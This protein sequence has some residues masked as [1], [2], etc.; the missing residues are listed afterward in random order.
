MSKRIRPEALGPFVGLALLTLV[1]SSGRAADAPAPATRRPNILWISAED[2]SAGTL[3]CY[4]GAARTPRIDS[5][6]AKGLRF[7]QAFSV[8]PVCAPSRSAIIT[9]VMPTTL[10][11][12]PMRCRATPPRHLVGFPRLLRDAG[13]F[14]TNAAKTDYNL[15]ASFD[16]GWHESNAKAHWRHRP[17]PRQPFFAVFNLDV[18]HESG[19]FEDKLAR[20]RQEIATAER[21]DPAR[22]R[23]P[24]YFPDTPAVREALAARLELAALLDRDVGRILDELAADG[25]EDD[26]IVFFWG[27]HGEGIPHGKRSLN[28]H[29]LRVPLVV[30]VPSRFADRAGHAAVGATNDTL[31]SLLD[32][33]PT[34]LDLAGV[35]IPGWMEGHAVLGPRARAARFVVGARDRM[36]AIS[37]FARTVREPRLRYVRNF[38][39]W[40]DGDDLPPYADGV[41]ITGALRAARAAGSLPP[42]AEWFARVTRPVEELYDVVTDPDGVQDLAAE[43][44]H[45]ADVARLR[46]GLRDWMRATRDT[47]ILPEPILRREAAV[48]G[49][50]WAVFH[51]PQGATAEEAAAA[52]YDALLDVAW[53][54]GAGHAPDRFTAGL[55][56]PDPALRFWAAAGVGWS[57]VRHGDKAA[58]VTALTPLLDDPDPVVRI[59]AARWLVPCGAAESG[60]AALASLIDA[61]ADVR[62]AALASVEELGTAARPLWERVARLELGKDERYASDIAG[63]IRGWIARGGTHRGR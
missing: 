50:E 56:S 39:P 58:A 4:G 26:T 62:F 55:A 46:T 20:A 3:G 43:P 54:V 37:G 41:A 45:A 47:G 21:H 36:D 11:S 29:G 18:T 61:D 22:V 8:A 28:E 60:L 1:S 51:P 14:C 10:G 16:P 63:R 12:L 9:G 57:A 59:A 19:L 48:A 35:P 34:V 15:A 23:V 7:D 53:D 42:G 25:L 49:S 24:P 6:A 27:D 40:L 32:L 5:L 33:G 44:A 52:R 38:L 17:D 30:S 13:W 31:V 2:I